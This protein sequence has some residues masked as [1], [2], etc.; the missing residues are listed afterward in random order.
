VENA[1]VGASGCA[2]ENAGRH[3]EQFGVAQIRV[4]TVAPSPERVRNMVAA[5][6]NLTDGKGTGF[7]LFTGQE[8]LAASD[9]LSV[10]WTSGK[11]E[12][13]RLVD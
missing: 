1:L 11:G 5:V 4:P 10:D 12:R 13:V 2:P 3:V 8:N 6:R 7:F 9:P